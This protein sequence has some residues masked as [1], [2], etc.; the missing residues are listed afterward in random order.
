MG[1]CFVLV[2]LRRLL[3]EAWLGIVRAFGTP[4]PYVSRGPR[5]AM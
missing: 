2:P 4:Q 1:L 3:I 5:P